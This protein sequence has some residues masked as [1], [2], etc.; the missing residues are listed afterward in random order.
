MGAVMPRYSLENLARYQY[1][2][3]AEMG[4][5]GQYP[6]WRTIFLKQSN[7]PVYASAPVAPAVCSCL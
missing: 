4:A 7:M 2:P 5:G 6:S 3:S 1:L